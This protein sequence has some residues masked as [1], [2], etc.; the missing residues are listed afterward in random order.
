MNF[1]LINPYFNGSEEIPKDTTIVNVT[2]LSSISRTTITQHLVKNC[3]LDPQLNDCTILT[4][5]PRNFY[6][7]VLLAKD[8]ELFYDEDQIPA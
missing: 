4:I 3:K 2:Q 5:N 6:L 8:Y 7:D 1:T